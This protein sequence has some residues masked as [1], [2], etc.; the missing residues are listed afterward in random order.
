MVVEHNRTCY[1]GGG[2]GGGGGLA[3]A[4]PGPLNPNGGGAGILIVRI[5]TDNYPID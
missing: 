1:W 5:S 4:Y 3:N 2:A